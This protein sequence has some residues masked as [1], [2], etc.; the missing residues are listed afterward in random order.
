MA[1]DGLTSLLGMAQSGARRRRKQER[2]DARKDILLAYGLQAVADPLVKGV[3]GLINAPYRESINRFIND[4]KSATTRSL[5]KSFADV[6]QNYAALRDQAKSQNMTIEELIKTNART[7]LNDVLVQQNPDLADEKM[8]NRFI[9]AHPSFIQGFDELTK[10]AAKDASS[11]DA[12]A[13]G[14]NFDDPE[15]AATEIGVTWDT[16]SHKPKNFIESLTKPIGRFITGKSKEESRAEALNTGLLA[17]G[18]SSSNRSLWVKA[19][20]GDKAAEAEIREIFDQLNEDS[21]GV[22]DHEILE[23]INDWA[24]NNPKVSKEWEYSR[25]NAKAQLS[26]AAGL[27]AFN[28]RMLERD[29]T[30]SKE[31]NNNWFRLIDNA[32]SELTNGDKTKLNPSLINKYFKD[33]YTMFELTPEKI[34]NFSSLLKASP[35]FQAAQ[36]KIKLSAK[37]QFFP[38]K[39][40]D[41]L[42][43]NDQKYLDAVEDRQ[44]EKIIRAAYQSE[45]SRVV[46]FQADQ[47]VGNDGAIMNYGLEKP[48]IQKTM[49]DLVL[50]TS[51]HIGNERLEIAEKD[52]QVIIINPRIGWDTTEVSDIITGNILEPLPSSNFLNAKK[53]TFNDFRTEMDETR[54]EVAAQTT[55]SL[56]TEVQN[57]IE[58]PEPLEG[59]RIQISNITAQDLRDFANENSKT[60]VLDVIAKSPTDVVQKIVSTPNASLYS[61]KGDTTGAFT[62]KGRTKMEISNDG[63]V[64]NFKFQGGVVS[65]AANPDLVPNFEDIPEGNIKDDIRVVA[66]EYNRLQTKYADDPSVLT[67]SIS[68]VR[69]QGIGRTLDVGSENQELFNDQKTMRGIIAAFDFPGPFDKARPLVEDF[70][71][72]VPTGE[73]VSSFETEDNRDSILAKPSVDMDSIASLI[74]SEEGLLPTVSA[75]SF[76]KENG[77]F[78]RDEVTENM[79]LSGG[80]GH[81]LTAAERKKYPPG[82]EIPQ[83]QIDKW[84]EEDLRKAYEAAVAQNKQ[85]STP[86]DIGRLTAVNFQLGTDWYKD[87]KE[88]WKAMVAGD[89]AL[90]TEEIKERSKWY[91]QTPARAESLINSFPT[92]KS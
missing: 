19:D 89:Y 65:L 47:Q 30:K 49:E 54:N 88:T 52:K 71:A 26:H 8:R 11:Q 17:H 41:E 66:S 72:S 27:N 79:P 45:L 64:W 6:P 83:E 70:L 78:V 34:K 9:A 68:G 24:I 62:S 21:K 31:W 1:E 67:K 5:V 84:F 28:V 77:K 23:Y 50:A 43:T 55:P 61:N 85:L 76:S 51:V 73:T 69:T 14:M 44:I 42:E 53:I 74:K 22:E 46:E 92:V 58:D 15:K 7:S 40:V 39:G 20:A 32:A 25:A 48:Q 60:D 57:T 12:I 87:H 3:T 81:L 36:S 75:D 4:P 56:E 91:T 29:E 2:R 18:L 33:Q 59:E 82:S 63:D 38:N 35:V 13:R 90:A 16:Y 37:Q 10:K 86:L 80:Y